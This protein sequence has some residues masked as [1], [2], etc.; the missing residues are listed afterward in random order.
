MPTWEYFSQPSNLAFHNLVAK[1]YKH[2]VPKN[3]N[4]LLGLGLN[5]CIQKPMFNNE[6][7]L[8]LE[9][10]ERDLLLKAYFGTETGDDPKKLY[11]KSDWMP[12][13]K[14]IPEEV[15]ARL[16]SSLQYIREHI[17]SADVHS[18]YNLSSLQR[19]LLNDLIEHPS[20]MVIQTDK[21]L[22][23]AIID[24][25][26]YINLA[27]NDHLLNNDVYQK[28]H[29]AGASDHVQ[30]IKMRLLKFIDKHFKP[31]SHERIYLERALL[32]VKDPFA[33][34]YLLAKIH[35]SPMTTRPI[36]SVSGSLLEGL[37]KWTDLQL[38]K[39]CTTLPYIFRSS[40][41]VALAARKVNLQ[42]THFPAGTAL[43]T[44]DA[45]AM[46][47]NIDT[48]H[49]LKTISNFLSVSKPNLCKD[50]GLSNTAILEALE[51]LMTCTF[52]KLGD[53]CWS[54][55][56]GTAMGSPA[57]PMYATLYFAIHEL[58]VIPVFQEHLP[59]YGRYIDDALGIWMPNPASSLTFEAFQEKFNKFGNLT[60]CFTPLSMSVNF[61]DISL[62]IKQNKIVMEPYEKLLNLYLYIPPRSA[63]P[64]GG[65]FSLLCGRLKRIQ[66]VTTCKNQL[67][68]YL[69]KLSLRLYK[70]GYSKK[71]IMSSLKRALSRQNNT[72]CNMANNKAN[73]LF[74]HC[75]FHPKAVPS[76]KIQHLLQTA[77]LNP[78][79]C[80]PF[81]QLH[82]KNKKAFGV[83]TI[84]VCYHRPHNLKHF[85]SPRKFLFKCSVAQHLQRQLDIDTTTSAHNPAVDDVNYCTVKSK[86]KKKICFNLYRK[87]PT[88]TTPEVS[89]TS[90]I[91]HTN[92]IHH[93]P[94]AC[95][96]VTQR[97]INNPYKK[98]PFS[99]TLTPTQITP[100]PTTPI[101]LTTSPTYETKGPN[102][103]IITHNHVLTKSMSDPPTM[104]RRSTYSTA[105]VQYIENPY[106][107]ARLKS[108]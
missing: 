62:S 69:K 50:L 47:T 7:N 13:T 58:E 76:C 6:K 80:T 85:L 22:G 86:A 38:Q 66:E 73:S 26:S 34:F 35:K 21:N 4:L 11:I 57:A 32:T 91:N 16:N 89:S 79:N 93:I 49:A 101:A 31:K 70:R 78:P 59:L 105:T 37:G 74:L 72:V 71:V 10:F 104:V 30:K 84:T 39:I 94:N 44:A 100:T 12:P 24:R 3:L 68:S 25:T 23:P 87:R 36:V 83:T 48:T 75:T 81:A 63:H 28:L 106:K 2:L 5:Y 64:P 53:T 55:E 29:K 19:K 18:G 1:E 43:F 9:R 15:Q 65:L 96:D 33:Y 60:W 14:D 82:A 45:T 51:I 54:Q 20:L 97:M 103:N 56:S 8:N 77:L 17:P 46:Y 27:L 61:L 40:K 98:R 41:C 42:T 102:Q 67:K 99:I 107:R 95:A 108:P 92:H 90:G 52:F 88:R